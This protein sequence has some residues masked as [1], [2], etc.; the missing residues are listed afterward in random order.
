MGAL[1]HTLKVTLNG[2]N[3]P[4]LIALGSL[5]PVVGTTAGELIK[6]VRFG[7]QTTGQGMLRDGRLIFNSDRLSSLVL[8]TKT[9]LDIPL[10]QVSGFYR[11]KPL[12]PNAHPFTIKHGE[13]TIDM[14]AIHGGKE[15]VDQLEKEIRAAGGRV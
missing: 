5:I 12:F 2:V 10:S 11:G 8:G 6:A 13:T 14:V 1:E 3:A 9:V 7:L 15:F 4:V